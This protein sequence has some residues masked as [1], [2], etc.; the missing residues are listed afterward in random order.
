MTLN[1]KLQNFSMNTDHK[2][3]FQ[4][5]ETDTGFNRSSPLLFHMHQSSRHSKLWS[6]TFRALRKIHSEEEYAH[7]SLNRSLRYMVLNKKDKWTESQRGG[8]WCCEMSGGSSYSHVAIP[9]SVCRSQY[10]KDQGPNS[11]SCCWQTLMIL[12]VHYPHSGCSV[13]FDMVT[14]F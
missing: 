6:E 1:E 10:P 13:N 14:Q 3:W 5:M 12:L 7:Q 4:V 9:Y 2:L 11:P 8:S